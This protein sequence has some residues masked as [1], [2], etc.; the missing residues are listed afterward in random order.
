MEDLLFEIQQTQFADRPRAERLLLGFLQ[1]T[2]TLDVV[3]VELRPLAVSLNSFNG[4][5]RLADGR[6]LFF[7]T[8]TEPDSVIG[9]YYN[10]AT[11]AE[12]GYPVLQPL[13]SSTEAGRQ[14][15]IYEVVEDPSVF[16]VAWTIENGDPTLLETLMVAQHDADRA[17]A[18][19][20]RDT[21]ANDQPA[22]DAPVHQLFY[23]RLAGARFRQFYPRDGQISLP[24]G[25]FDMSDIG[26]ARWTV[27]GQQY[28][29]NL[30]ELISSSLRL[31][32]P[33]RPGSS[34]IGHGDAH[35]GNVF[36]HIADRSLVYFD[37]AFAGRHDPLLDLAK[38]LFHNTFAMWMYFPDVL[39]DRLTINSTITPEAI[40]VEHDHSLL[41]VRQTFLDSKVRH[42]LT[43]T[44]AE[45]ARRGWLR[46]DWKALLKAALLC[47]PLLTMNLA[48][49][50]RFSPE[51][52][53]LG[54]AYAV[55][56]G[57][58]SQGERS[59]IDRAL[60]E[61]EAAVH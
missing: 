59:P 24:G 5:L 36:L 19:I 55:E 53:L 34:V 13:F 54:L 48:D 50:A 32:R 51:I 11:L 25:T 33:G 7:K 2:F 58:E 35:N 14:L 43:P 8:H 40:V 4:F 6:R 26:A 57:G 39:R 3:S 61:V 56:M 44:V 46:E 47:C 37:P 38:P 1:D 12:A 9:E 42:A 18:E 31:L 22:A 20:Y 45:L 10:A 21:L 29:A 23:H 17:L 16:D 15:L 30:D 27:N 28:P 52:G 60:D 49:R 41:P